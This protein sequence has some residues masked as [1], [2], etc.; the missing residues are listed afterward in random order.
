MAQGV[1][2]FMIQS[3]VNCGSFKVVKSSSQGT[4]GEV[5]ASQ[6]QPQGK[7]SKK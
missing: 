5:E 1:P 4:Q 3:V 2:D 7:M 6:S